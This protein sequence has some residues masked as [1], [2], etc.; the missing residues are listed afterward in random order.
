[1]QVVIDITDE[2]SRAMLLAGLAATL[3]QNGFVVLDDIFPTI[4][5]DALRYECRKQSMESFKPAGTGR[6]SKH[7]VDEQVR[8]DAIGWITVATPSCSAYLQFMEQLRAGLNQIMYLGLFDYECHFA[9]YAPGA[10]YKKH[11]DAFVGERNRALSTIYYL[12][13]DWS[14]A[15]AGELV[16]YTPDGLQKIATVLPTFNRMVIFLS[17]QFPHEVLPTQ[18]SRYSLTGWFRVKS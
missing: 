5:A 9:H 3:T 4:V 1:M 14:S 12:N 17:E 7:Q 16:L 8:G 2:N 11:V 18:C 10:F 6:N 13:P 15:D